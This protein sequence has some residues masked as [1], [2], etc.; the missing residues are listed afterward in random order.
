MALPSRPWKNT[1][2]TNLIHNEPSGTYFARVQAGGKLIR[3]SL[4]TKA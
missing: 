1:S 3:H 2:Y 4:K